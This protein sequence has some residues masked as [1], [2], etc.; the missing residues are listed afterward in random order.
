M[1]LIN[2]TTLEL[3]EVFDE[4]NGPPY[5]ILSHRWGE[6]ELSFEEYGSGVVRDGLGYH[7]VLGTC[8]LARHRGLE[9]IWIDTVCIDKRSSA[10]LSEA[11]NSMFRWYQRAE[12]CYAYLSDVRPS[13]CHE[14]GPSGMMRE[15][16]ESAWFTRGWTLQELIAPPE[17]TFLC[18]DWTV[19]GSKRSLRAQNFRSALSSPVIN[20]DIRRITGIPMDV[21]D[22]SVKVYQASVA[23]RMSWAANRS[24]TR[25]E[26]IAYCMLGL[27]DINMPLLYGEGRRAFERLQTKI[28]SRF[29]DESIFAFTPMHDFVAP[30][31]MN[32]YGMLAVSPAEFAGCG[33]HQE[34]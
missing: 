9:W 21:L 15:F 24:T 1:R 34:A 26:D 23:Q 30:W 27:F 32:L 6:E 31:Q 17:V 18:E 2:T 13:A 29:E 25:P 28:N 20:G 11:I 12:V 14:S 3:Q 4:I 33:A 22:D 10:E 5:A 19:I 7:K 16:Q 8:A